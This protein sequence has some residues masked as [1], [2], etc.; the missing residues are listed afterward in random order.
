MIRSSMWSGVICG[1]LLIRSVS[2]WADR[3]SGRMSFREPFMAR[4]MGLRAVATM[5]ASG[6]FPPVVGRLNAGDADR[7]G[8]VDGWIERSADRGYRMVTTAGL[9]ARADAFSGVP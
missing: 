7:P 6:M 2:T 4:P 1:T 9:T 5:T 8:A 3:S